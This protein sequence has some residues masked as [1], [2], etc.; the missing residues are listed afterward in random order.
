MDKHRK[1]KIHKRIKVISTI[2]KFALLLLIIIGLPL[3]IYFFEPQLIDSMSSM[4][5][6]NALFEH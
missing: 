2:L 3:Y 4:E 1:D 6:V 5:N